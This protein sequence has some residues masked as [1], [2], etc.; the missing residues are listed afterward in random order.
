MGMV[1]HV[2]HILLVEC[3]NRPKIHLLSN[4]RPN[5][6]V[7]FPQ[8]NPISGYPYTPTMIP[9]AYQPMTLQDSAWHMNMGASSH[10][11]DNTFFVEFDEFG[12][13]VKDYRTRKLLLRCDSSGDLY[14]VRHQ[15]PPST[16]YVLLSFSSTTW[17]RRI[18]HPGDDVLRR[19]ES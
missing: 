8:L 1:G 4:L 2:E 12:Y 17:H 7:M 18:R 14:P 13:S 5:R 11:V 9:Q 3:N 16:P 6:H 15:P 10:L 19:L